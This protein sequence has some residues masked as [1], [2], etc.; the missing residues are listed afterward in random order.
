VSV[1]ILTTEKI[2]LRYDLDGDFDH[3]S[4]PDGDPLQ[5]HVLYRLAKGDWGG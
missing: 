4:V 2:G 1:T 5:P 3:P